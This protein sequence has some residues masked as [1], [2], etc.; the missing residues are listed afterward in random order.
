[1]ANRGEIFKMSINKQNKIV[2]L[3]MGIVQHYNPEKYWKMRTEVI[4]KNSKKSKLTRLVYLYRIKRSDAFNCASMG[5]D[6]G[7]GAIFKTPP[8]LPH[9][10]NGIIVSPNA[11][12]GK[13]CTIYQQVTI[14]QDENEKAPVIGDNCLIGAGAKLIGNIIIG[15]NVKI[16]ANA[17]IIKDVPSDCTVVGIPG[18]IVEKK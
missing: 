9:H 6:L 13:N 15:D 12:I 1:M 10:L 8:H 11:I 7:S 3:V 4:S 5:T 16:G 17:V 18:R 14:G 2:N